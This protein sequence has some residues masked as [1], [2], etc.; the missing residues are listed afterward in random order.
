MKIQNAEFMDNLE[1]CFEDLSQ[2]WN[3]IFV[4]WSFF[5]YLILKLKNSNEMLQK[6]IE[7]PKK[8]RNNFLKRDENFIVKIDSKIQK[9]R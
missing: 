9:H 4:I 2:K 5:S 7:M 1:T 3:N 6:I 8:Y